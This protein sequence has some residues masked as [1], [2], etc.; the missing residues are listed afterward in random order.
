MAFAMKKL[1]S[2]RPLPSALT[3]EITPR[4]SNAI[5]CPSGDHAGRR[6]Q[7]VVTGVV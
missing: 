6:G 7:Q 3:I 4:S 5:R 1:M 2:F